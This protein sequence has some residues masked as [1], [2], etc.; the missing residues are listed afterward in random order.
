IKGRVGIAVTLTKQRGYGSRKM[1]I[2]GS[3]IDPSWALTVYNRCGDWRAKFRFC[4][5]LMEELLTCS[6]P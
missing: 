6:P 1:R 5:S 4:P 2:H 3:M